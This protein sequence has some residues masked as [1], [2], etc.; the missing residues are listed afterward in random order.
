MS[1][2]AVSPRPQV[3]TE[4]QPVTKDATRAIKA[5]VPSRITRLDGDGCT[6][7]SVRFKDRRQT[8]AADRRDSWRGWCCTTRRRDRSALTITLARRVAE[9]LGGWQA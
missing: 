2:V 8:D 3:G 4:P 5:S 6:R 7:V 9:P 1:V